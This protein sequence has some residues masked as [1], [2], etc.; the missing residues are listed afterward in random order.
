[1][2]NAYATFANHGIYC[3]PVSILEI[4][5][6]DGNA[7]PVPSADCHRVLKR[8][9]A[10]SVTYMLNGVVDGSIYGRTG[11]AMSLDNRQVAGKTGT[12]ND[13]AAVWFVGY[14]PQL[15]AAV[16][17]GDPRG[18][19]AHPMKDVTIAGKYYSQVFGSTLPGPIWHDAMEAAL[20]GDEPED[21]DIQT[22]YGWQTH[23]PNEYVYVPS[24]PKPTPTPTPETFDN[25]PDVPAPAPSDP[26]APVPDPTTAPAPAG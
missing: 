17:V 21:F 12:T 24:A 22:K 1:M 19:Y 23:G 15:S 4:R 9:V 14:T 5:D 10:D 6:R 25:T 26:A 3:K 11:Q 20:A 16:W 2:A 18:G 8:E 7:L 13:S